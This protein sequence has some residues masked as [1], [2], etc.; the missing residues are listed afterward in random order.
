[1]EKVPF[2]VELGEHIE[3]AKTFNLQDYDGQYPNIHWVIARNMLD[4]FSEFERN[5]IINHRCG[6]IKRA[7]DHALNYLQEKGLIVYRSRGKGKRNIEFI[8]TDP[9]Y[10]DCQALDF[11]RQK[12]NIQSSV[13]SF[14]KKV[15]LMHPKQAPLIASEAKRF[16]NKLI[17]L[18]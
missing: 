15:E 18:D 11:S 7:F 13:K 4:Q 12:N 8:S 10:S 1:M 3:E 14:A 2:Y 9:D 16:N 6:Q 17:G 5:L